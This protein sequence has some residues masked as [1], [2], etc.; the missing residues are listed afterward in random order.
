MA[1]K[2]SAIQQSPVGDPLPPSG[3]L[4][5]VRMLMEGGDKGMETLGFKVIW[6]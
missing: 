6:S 3:G 2:P 1:G 5:V 4:T